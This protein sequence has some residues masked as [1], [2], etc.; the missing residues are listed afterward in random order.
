ML[1]AER[2]GERQEQ[3]ALRQVADQQ[4]VEGA[5]LQICAGTDLHAPADVR[6]VRDD[7]VVH[8]AATSLTVDRDLD[9]G[10]APACENRERRPE[11]RDLSAERLRRVVRSLC[12]GSA[13]PSAGDVREPG[14]P[15]SA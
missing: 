11:V 9:L 1:A 5:V 13:H 10:V 2:L 8:P 14:L 15:L 6:A 4:D 3:V 7:D 12:D